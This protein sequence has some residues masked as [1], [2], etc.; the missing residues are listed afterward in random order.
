MGY[1]QIKKSIIDEYAIEKA[2]LYFKDLSEDGRRVFADRLAEI[3][4]TTRDPDFRLAKRNMNVLE[5]FI[6]P[7]DWTNKIKKINPMDKWFFRYENG[8]I[9]RS[10]LSRLAV[11]NGLKY[12]TKQWDREYHVLIILEEWQ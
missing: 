6:E 7:H 1:E 8:A 11:N 5:C 2:I 12:V 4:R 10:I 3:P 9:I